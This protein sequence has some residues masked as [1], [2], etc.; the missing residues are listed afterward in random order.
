MKSTIAVRHVGF[1]HLGLLGPLLEERGHAVLWREAGVGTPAATDADGADLLVVLGGPI[2][3]YGEAEYPVLKGE[4]A[5]IERRLAQG[6]P[7]LGICLGAQLIARAMGARVYA[8]PQKVIGWAP[9]E[10]TEDGHRS[11]LARLEE[12]DHPVLHWHGD[13]FDLPKE[14]TRLAGS[15]FYENE[16]FAHDTVLALQFHLEVEAA[17]IEHLTPYGVA[18]LDNSL[19]QP[20]AEACA[21]EGRYEFMLTINPLNV[22][23]GTGSPVNPIAVF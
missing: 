2:G 4:L 22:I 12:G 7:M 21:E 5:L 10:L 9:L 14:A 3:A 13:T 8:G 18:L 17:E 11:C 6:R 16:A 1:E 15:A 23:G 20:L 19:L